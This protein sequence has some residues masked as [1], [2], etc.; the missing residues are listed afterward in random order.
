[1][2][3]AR[4][5]S[6]KGKEIDHKFLNTLG[7]NKKSVEQDCKQLNE[8]ILLSATYDTDEK[9]LEELRIKFMEMDEN[10]SGD[11]DITEL[12]RA[13]EKLGKNKNQLELR[14]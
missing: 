14:R 8:E 7:K 13:M 4:T 9:T 10:G 3:H 2:D 1:M 5:A 12:G 6:K 11:I